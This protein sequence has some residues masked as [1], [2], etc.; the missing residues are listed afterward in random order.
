MILGIN[1]NYKFV[2]KVNKIGEA[3]LLVNAG[4]IN[5]MQQEFD[6]NKNYIFMNGRYAALSTKNTQTA[7]IGNTYFLVLK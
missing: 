3:Y 6:G 7:K 5:A 1:E 2:I 4:K